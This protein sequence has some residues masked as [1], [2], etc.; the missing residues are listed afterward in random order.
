MQ[1]LWEV[2]HSPTQCLHKKPNHSITVL[3]TFP[4]TIQNLVQ[5]DLLTQWAPKWPSTSSKNYSEKKSLSSVRVQFI[6]S[7]NWN[8]KPLHILICRIKTSSRA[9][10]I[11]QRAHVNF[12]K[13]LRFKRLHAKANTGGNVLTWQVIRSLFA[14]DPWNDEILLLGTQVS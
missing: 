7:A 9:A 1:W 5:I 10:G 6:F 2:V 14:V 13:S 3:T 12:C 8:I 4:P 11:P